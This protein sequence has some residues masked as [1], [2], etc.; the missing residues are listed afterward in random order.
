[1]RIQIIEPKCT[2]QRLSSG[3]SLVHLLHMQTAS[4]SDQ[5]QGARSDEDFR[6]FMFA[7]RESTV[8]TLEVSARL[9]V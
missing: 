2:A 8:S 9:L 7:N 6:T 3:R 5:I 1:M 4:I